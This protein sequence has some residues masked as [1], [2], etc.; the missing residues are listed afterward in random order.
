MEETKNSKSDEAAAAV[1]VIDENMDI[2]ILDITSENVE[3]TFKHFGG[4][5][6]STCHSVKNTKHLADV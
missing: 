2:D 6:G 1:H 3:E 5:E 4:I